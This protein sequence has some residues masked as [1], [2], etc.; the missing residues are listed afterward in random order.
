MIALSLGCADEW[1]I[2]EV[3]VRPENAPWFE[4][5]YFAFIALARGSTS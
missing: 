4:E 2:E 1:R 5:A 3:D